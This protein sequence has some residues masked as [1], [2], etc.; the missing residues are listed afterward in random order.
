MSTLCNMS[1]RGG[2]EAYQSSEADL[3]DTMI[4]TIMD[5]RIFDGRE[6]L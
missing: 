5:Y 6:V 4:A 2:G 3:L 1:T